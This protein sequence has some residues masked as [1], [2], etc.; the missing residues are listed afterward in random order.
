MNRPLVVIV[1]GVVVVAIAFGMNFLAWQEETDGPAPAPVQ[2]PTGSL[3][4]E[5]V[6]AASG[7]KPSVSP[8]GGNAEPMAAVPAAPH[9][10]EAPGGA[11]P[12]F[13]VVRVNPQGDTVMAGRAEP[14]ARIII[15]DGDTEIGSATADG[16]GEW[17][18][19]PDRAL[20]AGSHQL[21]LEA[22]GA[23]G[24]EAVKSE[25]IV[26]LV[27]PEKGKDVAGQPS[28][29]PAKPLALQVPRDGTGASRVLQKPAAPV[30]EAR[31]SP[32]GEAINGSAASSPPAAPGVDT[33]TARSAAVPAI[34]PHAP[35]TAVTVVPALPGAGAA[36]PKALAMPSLAIEAVDYDQSGG[37]GLSG[38]AEPGSVVQLYLDNQFIGRATAG[39]DGLWSLSPDRQ[40]PPGIYTLRADRV[41]AD[42]KVLSRLEIPFS[43]AQPLNQLPPGNYVVVQ[44]GNSLWRIARRTY[45]EGIQYTVIYDANRDQI[46]E[47]DL[48]YP[49]QVFALPAT[50]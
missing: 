14:G 2:S 33:P 8:P 24:K 22:S 17:V 7:A 38:R 46:R 44:P 45:G 16:H 30:G 5:P 15:Y 40:V 41:D 43:R 25:A 4:A 11:A 36:P 29:Q 50:H 32:V 6:V 10:R 1:A 47:A 18:F 31:T 27:V 9:A 34:A 19:I 3:P 28:D 26:V 12:S 42:G 23:N 37:I 13:D 35:P 39:V 49:G 20:A 48:I 21:G